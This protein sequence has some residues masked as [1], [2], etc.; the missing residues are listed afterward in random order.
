MVYLARTADFS[1]ISAAAE[2]AA[3]TN[4]RISAMVTMSNARMTLMKQRVESKIKASLK[5]SSASVKH[6][7]PCCGMIVANVHWTAVS[8]CK[9]ANRSTGSAA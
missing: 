8:C 1:E 6:C 5:V 3:S 4:S 7:L 2:G 9:D